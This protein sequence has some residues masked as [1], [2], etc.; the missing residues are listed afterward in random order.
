MKRLKIDW[1]LLRDDIKSLNINIRTMCEH[2]GYSNTSLSH[3]FASWGITDTS[4][5]KVLAYMNKDK[6]IWGRFMYRPIYKFKIED[7]IIL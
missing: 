7:Y 1:K 4:L 2:I 3:A 6:L 5:N